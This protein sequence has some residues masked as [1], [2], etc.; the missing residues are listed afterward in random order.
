MNYKI[1][2][3]ESNHL[4]NDKSKVMVNGAICICEDEVEEVNRYI[5]YLKKK[6]NYY[7]ELKW[8]KVIKKQKDFYI[9]LID[10]FFD[11][12]MKFK[13]TF[14]PNK[15]EA[16]HKQ[17]G[18]TFDEFYYIV[19][20]YTIRNFI[21]SQNNYKIYLDYK[22]INGGKRIKKMKEIFNH[23]GSTDVF[24]IQS[25]E[26]QI[27]QLCDLFIGAIS[28]KNRDDIEHESEIKNFIIEYLE[29]KLGY[30]LVGT[31]PWIEKFN[32]FRWVLGNR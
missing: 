2:C 19:Y 24:I 11:S 16:L 32:I 29:Q 14:I 3:D 6:H 4:L 18:Y 10:Y 7:N 23:R 17:Y 20:H 15:K 22:D 26:A 12:N 5:K 27:L 8:T 25:Q 21:D 30:Q 1:F 28:Y 13:A 9:E 31:A